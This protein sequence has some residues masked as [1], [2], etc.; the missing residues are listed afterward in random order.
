MSVL[1]SF[2][3]NLED[4]LSIK[5]SLFLSYI[6][7]YIYINIYNLLV[8]TNN[9]WKVQKTELSDDCNNSY[10]KLKSHSK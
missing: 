10:M 1:F 9:T 6:Y 8:I 2:L 5:F 3:Y 7:I 4:N